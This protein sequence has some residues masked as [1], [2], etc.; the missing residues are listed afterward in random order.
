LFAENVGCGGS[1]INFSGV[2]RPISAL[3]PALKEIALTSLS[4]R[5]PPLWS[6]NERR[7]TQSIS[8]ETSE[9]PIT[10]TPRDKG[11]LGGTPM[12]DTVTFYRTCKESWAIM[13]SGESI[14]LVVRT[15]VQT[16]RC[17]P[18]RKRSSLKRLPENL[19]GKTYSYAHFAARLHSEVVAPRCKPQ[20]F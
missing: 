19:T 10:V 6:E 9:L 4:S 14:L 12:M 13:D 8:C 7:S 16:R 5:R 17:G 2:R 20:P 11:I 18:K 3:S 15:N 1:A